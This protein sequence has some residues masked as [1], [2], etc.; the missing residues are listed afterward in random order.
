[1]HVPPHFLMLHELKELCLTYASEEVANGRFKLDSSL[2]D[3]SVADDLTAEWVLAERAFEAIL[4]WTNF[5]PY[6]CSPTGVV[7]RIKQV[8]LM[9][10]DVCV[11]ELNDRDLFLASI[12]IY[13]FFDP[14]T[15]TIGWGTTSKAA[16]S[17]REAQHIL[18]H[19]TGWT[20]CYRADAPPR[21]VNQIRDRMETHDTRHQRRERRAGGRPNIQQEALR[22]YK[23]LYPNGHKG[24]ATW[25]EVENRTGY[26]QATLRRALAAEEA[27]ASKMPFNTQP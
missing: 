27:S 5:K 14:S 6:I 8:P 18:K 20:I 13:K 4:N 23:Q 15:G 17:E 7:L 16:K 12:Q 26:A 1:M 3:S 24:F 25:S 9:E 21:D 10:T 2:A 22:A 19:F 11:P